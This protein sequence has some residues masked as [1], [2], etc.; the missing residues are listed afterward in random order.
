MIHGGIAIKYLWTIQKIIY[1]IG[2]FGNQIY[3]IQDISITH[4]IV[5]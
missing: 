5:E 1:V 3:T 4:T 2:L